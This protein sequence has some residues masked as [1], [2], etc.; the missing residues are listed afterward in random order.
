MTL[1]HTERLQLRP[2]T[3]DDAPAYWPLVSDPAVLRHTGESPLG[4]LDEVR[5]LLTAARL[6]RARLRPA[7]VHRK[8]DG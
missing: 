3:L 4:S 7:G 5:A 6:R 8:G 1:L 2:F